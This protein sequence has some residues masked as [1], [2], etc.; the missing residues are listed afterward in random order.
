I[1]KVKGEAVRQGDQVLEV[2]NPQRV[3]IEGTV[4]ISDIW[5]VK[6]GAQVEVSLD[7]PQ[8]DLDVEKQVFTGKIVFVAV[9]A[10]SA[11]QGVQ[12]WAEVQNPG[13]VLRAGLFASMKIKV[14]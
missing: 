13:N 11:S 8:V 5:H 2:V 10:I 7:L 1:Q 3:R 4:K 12:V 6:P 9:N 14:D